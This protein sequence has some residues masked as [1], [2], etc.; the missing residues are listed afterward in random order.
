MSGFQNTRKT[1]INTNSHVSK[2]SIIAVINNTTIVTLNMI[3]NIIET[4]YFER[5]M[6]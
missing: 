6:E 1:T 5:D 4:P 3:W 2:K